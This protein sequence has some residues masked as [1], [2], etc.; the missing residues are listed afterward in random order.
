MDK[1]EICRKLD[2]AGI[3]YNSK[4]ATE[5]LHLLY[6]AHCEAVMP[7]VLQAFAQFSAELEAAIADRSP[8][9]RAFVSAH[10]DQLQEQFKQAGLC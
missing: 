7:D 6:Q 3:P 9:L 2:A 8:E 10:I 4:W 1:Q 5:E